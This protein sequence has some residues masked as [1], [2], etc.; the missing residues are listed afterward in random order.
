MSFTCTELEVDQS[1]TSTHR[2]LIFKL[3]FLEVMSG[4]AQKISKTTN[5]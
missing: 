3:E 1:Y 2:V 5:V 4:S